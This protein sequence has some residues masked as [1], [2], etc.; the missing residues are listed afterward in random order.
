MDI[1]E[2][3]QGMGLGVN[4]G[5]EGRHLGEGGLAGKKLETGK[6]RDC[7]GESKFLG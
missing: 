2:V 5:K 6:L 7:S 4:W 3:G 1:R